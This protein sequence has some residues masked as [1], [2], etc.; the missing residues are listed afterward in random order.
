[1]RKGGREGEMEGGRKG[2][3]GGEGGR[4]GRREGEGGRERDGEREG[5]GER[6]REGGKRIDGWK[7][8][9]RMK[10]EEWREGGRKE[11]TRDSMVTRFIKY[12]YERPP[13][14]GGSTK[15]SDS[16]RLPPF[17]NLIRLTKGK[18]NEISKHTRGS[19]NPQDG[20]GMEW[21][22]HPATSK[23]ATG[24]A[25]QHLDGL[26]FYALRLREEQIKAF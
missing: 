13:F 12:L 24:K 8:G 6:E 14:N 23:Y 20:G 19:E 17:L 22:T 3:R 11:R 21:V 5:W 1:M 16:E 9:K 4:E 10:R 2:G 15:S 26:D 18:D 7:E 25:I